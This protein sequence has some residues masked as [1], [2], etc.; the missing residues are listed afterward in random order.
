M[1]I[2]QR[3]PNAPRTPLRNVRV[4]DELWQAA[5]AQ[6][7]ENGETV[8]DV[9]RRALE[10]YVNAYAAGDWVRNVRTGDV[11]Q[12]LEVRLTEVVVGLPQAWGTRVWAVSNVE[13]A[14]A[15]E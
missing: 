6:A 5:Q 7:A 1:S 3:V 12:V 9:V 14:E 2:V 11:R 8:S 10:R 13:P 15:P 4:S